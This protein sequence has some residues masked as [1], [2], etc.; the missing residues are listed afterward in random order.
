M[1]LNVRALLMCI[2]NSSPVFWSLSLCQGLFFQSGRRQS[3]VLTVPVKVHSGNFGGE[4]DSQVFC[5]CKT[6]TRGSVSQHYTE[7]K[8]GKGACCPPLLLTVIV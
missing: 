6:L 4:D 2:L 1:L 5:V 3:I 7:L 8:L